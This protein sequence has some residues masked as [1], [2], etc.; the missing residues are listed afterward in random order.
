MTPRTVRIWKDVHKWTSLVCTLFLF[1]LCLTGLP[2]IFHEE[3][4]RMLGATAA[5]DSIAA[6]APMISLDR[7]IEIGRAERP[8]E[9]ITFA[10]PDD[11]DPVWHLFF[12]AAINSPKVA[13]V[14]TIDG[15]TGRILRVGDSTRSPIVKFITDLH[16]DLFLGEKG[17]LFLGAIGL[18]FVA[19]I[20][21]GIVVYGPFMRRLD[22]GTMRPRARRLYWLDMHNLAGVVLTAWMLVVGLTGSINTLAQ[23]IARHWQRTEL[24]E[25]IAPWRNAPAPANPSS[26]QKAM[27]TA[28]ASAPGMEV[29]SIA[30][31]GSLFAGGHH[32]GVFLHGN[33]PLTSKLIMP[34]MINAADGTFSESRELPWYAKVLFVS[35][36]LHFGDYGGLPL[37]II[38]GLLDILTLIV[39]GSGLYLWVARWRTAPSWKAAARAPGLAA[40]VPERL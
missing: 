15:R 39:L 20:V 38:W 8:N 13:A 29:S 19:A 7:V 40:Q 36:P 27:E 26:V 30:M 9:A 16:T 25:M 17:M 3:I 6:D 5:P 4:D 21:S 32:Y 35:K 11:D 37:K 1:I 24:V 10:V 2:L 34:V 23:Q 18:C 31:P 33:T 28:L 12:A 22:F 14:M